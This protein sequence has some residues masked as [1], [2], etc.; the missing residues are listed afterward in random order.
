MIVPKISIVIPVYNAELY[1]EEC[2]NSVVVQNFNEYE[3]VIV[4]DGSADRSGEICD[5]YAQKHENISA[6]HQKN[7]GASAAR[8]AG[9]REAKGRYIAFVDADDT[10]EE[11]YLGK[12][13]MDMQPDGFVACSLNKRKNQAERKVLSPAEAQISVFSENGML[14]FPFG[15]VFDRDLILEKNIFFQEDIAICEDM[16]FVIEYISAVKGPIVW[17]DACGYNYRLNPTSALNGRFNKMYFKPA[18]LSEYEAF[19]RMEKYLIENPSVYNAWTLRKAK[20][21]VT[22]L[23]TMIAVNYQSPDFYAELQKQARKYWLKV[24]ISNQCAAS[25]RISVVL[26]AVSP[27]LELWVWKMLQ[28]LRY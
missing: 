4:D 15:K 2:L 19:K 13:Y 27:K 3:I 26:S 10:V 20:A 14:G 11:N 12:L 25:S 24:L 5:R 21:A 16:L 6:I 23:R 8:N 9:I 18:Y 7:R 28:K 22:C 1:L 17:K